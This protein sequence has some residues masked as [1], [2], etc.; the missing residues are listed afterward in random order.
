MIA[1]RMI[2]FKS[3]KKEDENIEFRTFLKCNAG[4]RALDEQFKRLHNELFAIYDCS[5]CRNCCKMYHGS[6]PAEDLEKDAEHLEITKEEFVDF[7]L[8]KNEIENTYETRHKPCDFLNKDGSCKLG[9]SKPDSCKKYPYTDQPGR[10]H[11]LYTVLEAVAVCPV[12][13][14]IYERLKKEYGFRYRK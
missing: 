3:E 7:Y 13:F 4:E 10:L 5:R 1:P 12:A 11:S 2:K 14:E 8:V 9:K 6:I